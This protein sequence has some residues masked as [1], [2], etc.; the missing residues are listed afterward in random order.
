MLASFQITDPGSLDPDLARDEPRSG[1]LAYRAPEL[2]GDAMPTAKSDIYA[3]GMILYQLVVGDFSASLAPGWEGRIA[4]P[5][6]R[7]D[8]LAAA[9]G[10]PA[11]RLA[12]AADLAD[13]LEAIDRRRADA[14]AA[15]QR[16]AAAEEARRA[17]EKQAARRPWVRAAI[18]SLMRGAA[19]YTMSPVMSTRRPTKNS[20][21]TACLLAPMTGSE[22]Y[23]KMSTLRG[24]EVDTAMDVSTPE[25][26]RVSVSVAML[27]MMFTTR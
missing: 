8:I 15:A 10:D 1:T 9:E 6:L 27:K 11:L 24:T 25:D 5:V 17:E 20:R 7:S 22:A 16:A 26:E 19:L 14:S 18:A 21:P 3:L 4:D 12:S 13:R 2:A 23:A